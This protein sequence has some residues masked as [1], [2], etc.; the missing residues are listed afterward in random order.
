M[1]VSLCRKL[2]C[3]RQYRIGSVEENLSLAH[4]NLHA[5]LA[6][7]LVARLQRSAANL[8]RSGPYLRGVKSPLTNNA[9]SLPNLKTA[10]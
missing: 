10:F 7:S 5:R 3:V 8:S 4:A 1:P 9:I 6:A 2:G